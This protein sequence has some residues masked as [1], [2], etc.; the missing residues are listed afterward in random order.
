MKLTARRI[1]SLAL[2]LVMLVLPLASCGRGDGGNTTQPATMQLTDLQDYKIIYPS[3]LDTLDEDSVLYPAILEFIKR[4]KEKTGVTLPRGEDFVPAGEDIPTDTKEILI[5]PTN[6]AESKSSKLGLHDTGIYFENNRL[7]IGG[8]SCAAAADALWEFM[9]TYL[10]AE[11]VFYPTTPKIVR[12][13]YPYANATLGGVSLR[14]YVIVRESRYQELAKLLQERIAEK[15]G[16]ILEI[17]GASA[18]PTDR[19]ILIGNFTGVR[20]TTPVTDRG[21]KVEMLG[22]RLSLRGDGSNGTTAAIYA[23]METLVGTGETLSLYTEAKSGT[24]DDLA[25]YSLGLPSVLPT[26]DITLPENA[27]GVWE[28]FEKARAE[29]P[30]EIRVL[31]RIIPQDFP[32]L[33]ELPEIYVAPNGDDN[34]AGTKE[35]PLATLEAALERVGRG[36]GI[37]W[38]RGG[39]YEMRKTLTISAEHSGTPISPLFIKAYPGETPTLTTFR[40]IST[41]WFSEMSVDDPL[42]D[43]LDTNVNF[44]DIVVVDLAEHGFTADDITELVGSGDAYGENKNQTKFGPTPY[45]MIGENEYS[46]CRY[47]NEGEP[48]LSFAYAYESGRVTS[49]I[50][51]EL[52]PG[53]ID[54]C[55]ASTQLDPMTPIPWEISL[56][57][58]NQQQQDPTSDKYLTYDNANDWLRYA[59]ILDWVDT[60]NIWF[61]GR[62]YSDWSVGKFNVHV[63][64]KADGSYVCFNDDADKPSLLSTMPAA[65][66]A[67][68][69]STAGAGHEYYLYNA[70]EALDV[71]GEWFIDV[72]NEG[73]RLYFYPPNEFWAA[74]EVTYTGTNTGSA[75]QLKQ[76]SYC[77]I[78]G[79]HFSGIADDGISG[80][81]DAG[82][83]SNIV[84][85]NCLFQN[86]G[87]CGVQIR[88]ASGASHV[89]VIYNEFRHS[90]G[91][92]LHLENRSAG[93]LVPDH[94]VIQNNYF[95]DPMPNHQIGIDASGC[96]TVISHNYLV[97][98]NINLSGPCFESIIEYNRCDG[99]SSD[100]GDG[101]QIYTYGLYSR[102]NHIRY[103]V[104]HGLNYSG[105]NIYN[106]GMASGNYSYFNIC[107]TLT[108]Y[109]PGGQKSFYVST[110]HNN[111]AYNNIMIGRDADRYEANVRAAGYNPGAKTHFYHGFKD[112]NRYIGDDL[113][114]ESTLFYCDDTDEGYIGST[115]VSDSASYSWDTLFR[116]AAGRFSGRSPGNYDVAA[117]ERR[118][119]NFTAAMRGAQAMFD[120]MDERGAEYDRRTAVL[121]LE[122]KFDEKVAEMLAAGATQEEAEIEAFR[123]GYGYTEDFFRQPAYNLYKNNILLGGD[124]EYY[125]DSNQDGIP[126]NA[127]QEF[128]YSDYLSNRGGVN[129]DGTITSGGNDPFARDFRIIEENF[130]WEDFSEIL[131]HADAPAKQMDE[132]D[133]GF[134]SGALERIRAAVPDY[135]DFVGM[136][137]WR[138]S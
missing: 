23:M 106:D 121:E 77:V 43:R 92:M 7:V 69:T 104:F 30:N 90:H 35:A 46:L 17:R 75:I 50:G 1:L 93:S 98:T 133:Y 34:A 76:V 68:S 37:I 132:A 122:A 100:V 59:P 6:R 45:L 38:M 107:S 52:Y 102:G 114:H 24:T 111:V 115:N 12:A 18:T 27:G 86:F 105:N 8:G 21:W 41:S 109:R 49:T 48:L 123:C 51:S 80:V 56:G 25:L 113:M 96:R 81:C 119:P 13:T 97:D 57:T 125:F 134:V 120:L 73:L 11:G 47:P 22:T 131:I 29:L 89:A 94:N 4:V 54:R 62:V 135:E 70:I 20:E 67:K 2:L 103:N 63:G 16:L 129:D 39:T 53:W 117:F 128:V 124:T 91:S 33:K 74:D 138:R 42:A 15:T 78:D 110:G 58:R 66:G 108:G 116:A 112:M 72:E 65:L 101:G 130:Y 5:G 99:G 31:E 32:V 9:D 40:S 137:D 55:E 79:L 71:P 95:Y 84:I 118:D 26:L 87:S 3:D 88:G 126:G 19:E 136:I 60:G 14:E 36:G 44:T 61:Y 10:T 127:A 28:R 85:E 64:R 82:K 83:L